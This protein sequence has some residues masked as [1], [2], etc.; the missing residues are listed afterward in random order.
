MLTSLKATGPAHCPYEAHTGPARGPNGAHWKFTLIAR[1]DKIQFFYTY[2]LPPWSPRC[3]QHTVNLQWAPYGPRTGPVRAS[4]GPRTGL[5]RIQSLAFRCCNLLLSKPYVSLC[6]LRLFVSFELLFFV[7]LCLSV[8]FVAFRVFCLCPFVSLR[9]FVSC[10]FLSFVSF[11][12]FCV[13]SRLLYPFL[14]VC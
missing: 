14:F 8:Y 2:N 9:I 6:V 4:C 3:C 7:F 12:V 11:C 1:R 13:F 10:V 5:V